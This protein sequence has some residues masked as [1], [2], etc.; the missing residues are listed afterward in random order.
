VYQKLA[1]KIKGLK[2]LGMPIGAI[3]SSLKINEKTVRKGL[4]FNPKD[5]PI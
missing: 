4:S 1:P 5:N 2:A 3:A